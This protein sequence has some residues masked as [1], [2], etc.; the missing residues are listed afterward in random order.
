MENKKRKF[1]KISGSENTF[2]QSKSKRLK[3]SNSKDSMDSNDSLLV[4]FSKIKFDLEKK[5]NEEIK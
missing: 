4:T 3:R 1:K 5:P 2:K